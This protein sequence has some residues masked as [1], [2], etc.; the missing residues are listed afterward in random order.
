M[1]PTDRRIIIIDSSVYTHKAILSQRYN[2]MPVARTYFSMLRGDLK[3]VGLTDSDILIIALDDHGR[4]SWRKQRDAQYKADRAGKREKA[5][6]DWLAG[7]EDVAAVVTDLDFAGYFHAVKVF[8]CEADDIAGVVCKQYIDNE[9]ILMTT[10]SD[11]YQLW[12]YPNVSIFN[13]H[14]SKKRYE[15][16]PEKFNPYEFIAKKAKKEVSD[17]LITEINTI[18]EYD[19]RLQLVNLLDLPDFVEAAVKDELNK[20]DI[21]KPKIDEFLPFDDF[22][23]IFSTKNIVTY[24][25]SVKIAEKHA[26]RLKSQR[27]K[28]K[29]ALVVRLLTTSL[30]AQD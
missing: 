15:I 19:T 6:L 5:N 30:N 25:K 11:W 3:K 14:K 4:G 7:F 16:K 18:E 1:F 9:I 13:I 28:R 2:P 10:D 17:N 8:Q 22:F 29:A 12:A 23:D 27:I 21:N 20:L 26:E 24:E